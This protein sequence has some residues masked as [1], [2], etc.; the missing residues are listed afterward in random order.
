MIEKF[1]WFFLT[2]THVTGKCCHL[3][4]QVLYL[5]MI[6]L[7]HCLDFLIFLVNL[8]LFLQRIFIFLWDHCSRNFALLKNKFLRFLW[9]VFLVLLLE[10]WITTTC[11]FEYI[12]IVI[13]IW[14]INL[15]YPTSTSLLPVVDSK[16]ISIYFTI[17][18]DRFLFETYLSSLLKDT[19]QLRC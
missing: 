3:M 9:N 15:F 16:K 11:S 6:L 13:I 12:W 17:V 1:V 7:Y 19:F 14:G 10:D 5:I 18:C 2:K 4:P 8:R